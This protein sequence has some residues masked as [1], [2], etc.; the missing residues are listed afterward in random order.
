MHQHVAPTEGVPKLRTSRRVVVSLSAIMG[1]LGLITL[2]GLIALWPNQADLPEKQPLFAH[3]GSTI[4][5]EIVDTHPG[6]AGGMVT[7]QP[8]GSENTILVHANPDVPAEDFS[9]GDRIRVVNLTS[10]QETPSGPETVYSYMDHHREWP[11]LVLFGLFV[12]AIVAVARWKGFAALV[13]LIGAMAMVWFFLLP[14]LMTGANALM[15]AL[16]TASVVMMI[17]MFLAHGISVK[18]VTALLG[19]FLGIASVAALAWWAIPATNLTPLAHEDMR[20]LFY[21]TEGTIDPKGIL[22]SAMVLTG[23][24]VLNDVTIT[25][26]A[27]VIE[28]RSSAPNRSRRSIFAMAMR[29]GRDHIASTVYTV[30]FAYVGASMVMIMLGATFDL[31]MLELF[32]FEEFA[33]QIVPILVVSIGLVLTIPL[34]TAITAWLCGDPIEVENADDADDGFED[35]L[36]EDTAEA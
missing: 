21:S 8:D 25:Q 4:S 28:L 34:T 23:V 30:A 27:T 12:I 2:I 22:L 32:T 14:A 26:S 24:G 9:I 33:A 29:I 3:E 18:T 19:T 5:G 36:E 17:V 7:M 35:E 13:G 16:V 11:M 6:E 20:R 31:T 15:V 10:L 1:A